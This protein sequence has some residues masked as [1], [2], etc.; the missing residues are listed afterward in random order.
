MTQGIFS[1]LRYTQRERWVEQ[2]EMLEPGLSRAE[3]VRAIVAASGRF[4]T[5]ILDGSSRLDQLAAMA[6]ARR[7][8]RPRVVITDATWKLGDGLADTLASKVTVNALDGPHVTYGVFSTRETDSFPR[9]WGVDPD[10]VAFLPWH[11]TLSDEELSI[12]TSDGGG[13]FSGGDSLRDYAPLVEAARR[14][15]APF[16]IATRTLTAEGLGAP[17]NVTVGPMTHE[18]LTSMT[19]A[20]SVVVVALQPR[21]DRS[22]GQGTYLNAMALGK[23]V[24][25]TDVAGVR[26]HVVDGETAVVVPAGD[27]VALETA[28][29]RLLDDAGER[30][31][32][33]EAARR[34]VLER[35]GPDQYVENLLRLADGGGRRFRRGTAGELEPSEPARPRISR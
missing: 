23:P 8:R 33:G 14:I 29:R 7:R 34:D 1:T 21:E 17:P 30:R 20:A 6:I 27:A 22:S 9:A 4:D 19:G 32:L 18:Q 2:V 10:R 25:V 35:F 15:D 16:T 28:I 11:H 26:D 24:V 12:Q 13:V 31:R 3:Y 5:L